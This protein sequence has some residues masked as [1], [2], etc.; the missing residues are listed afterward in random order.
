MKLLVLI[1]VLA[2]KFINPLPLASLALPII[3]VIIDLVSSA[4]KW[5]RAQWE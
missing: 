4:F 5:E 3:Y 2:R 1:F